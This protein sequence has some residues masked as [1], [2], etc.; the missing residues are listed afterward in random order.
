MTAQPA[1]S[2]VG[3]FVGTWLPYSE[4]FVYDQLRSHRRYHPRVFA[5]ERGGAAERFAFEP[6]H[7]LEGAERLAYL[8]LGRA[9]RFDRVLTEHP[10]ALL[11]AHFGTNGV[12]ARPF[13][14]RHGIPLVVTFHG[15]DVP[16]L[17]GRSRFTPR[18]ARYAALAGRMLR[19][20]RLLLPA[21]RD[22]AD[23][24]I[25]PIGADPK[26][27]EVLRLGVDLERFQPPKSRPETPTVLMVGRFVEKKAHLDGIRAF[28]AARAKV[29]EARL[30]IA[31]DGPLRAAYLRA[32]AELGL[33]GA[34]ELTG[35]VSS[36]RI[37]ELMATSHVVVAPSVT[38][39]SGDVESGVIVLKEAGAMGLPSLGTRHGGIPEII[40]HGETGFVVEEHDVRHLG[41]YLAMLLGD[42]GLRERLGRA[43]R[44]RMEAEYD[45][46]RQVARLEE[47]YDRAVA[48]D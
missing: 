40:A 29:P 37:R 18:Y 20:A 43:A 36:D 26:K 46:R 48:G 25:E 30:V 45:L 33:E 5:Y 19:E 16:A 2:D 11:H 31:G 28:A 3:V 8:T 34:V 35:A 10:A 13:A 17:I 7:A 47:L 14:A 12:H 9:P 21:S 42:S 32:V 24:L 6:V 41:A 23:R 44:A 15:H 1:S 39:R 22:L 27:I 4:T 38:A